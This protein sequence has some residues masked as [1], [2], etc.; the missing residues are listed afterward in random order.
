[1]SIYNTA[2][3]LQREQFLTKANYLAEKGRVVEIKERKP[4]RSLASNAYLHVILAYFGSQTGNTL[5]YVKTY[6]YKRLCNKDIFLRTKDDEYLGQIEYLRSS[7]S[8]SQ[9]EMTLSIER[10]RNWSAQEAGI[11]IPSGE[12]WPGIVEMHKEIARNKEYL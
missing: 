11:Y 6:Y 9:E 4:Q 5:E 7:A 10:F 1:M 2:Q 12:E 3:P 8:L